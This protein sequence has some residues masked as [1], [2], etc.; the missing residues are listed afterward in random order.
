MEDPARKKGRLVAVPPDHVDV[1][2]GSGHEH[3]S[4]QLAEGLGKLAR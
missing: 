2:F 1:R 3:K 4:D